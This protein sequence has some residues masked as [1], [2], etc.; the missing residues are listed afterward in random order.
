M[1]LI[2]E[3]SKIRKMKKKNKQTRIYKANKIQTKNEL[4][5]I[6]KRELS[7]VQIIFIT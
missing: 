2:S 7:F 4:N 5:D 3:R 6:C 1:L